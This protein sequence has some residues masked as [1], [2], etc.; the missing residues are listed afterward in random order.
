MENN[1]PSMLDLPLSQAQTSGPRPKSKRLFGTSRLFSQSQPQFCAPSYKQVTRKPLQKQT[2]SML[3]KL[4]HGLGQ[5]RII[6]LKC[7]FDEESSSEFFSIW[8]PVLEKRLNC[9]INLLST[10]FSFS[11]KCEVIEGGTSAVRDLCEDFVDSLVSPMEKA[12]KTFKNSRNPVDGYFISRGRYEI[13]LLLF[14]GYEN[15]NEYLFEI[16]TN[17]C[18]HLIEEASLSIDIEDLEFF[19]DVKFLS[20]NFYQTYFEAGYTSKCVKSYFRRK[21]KTIER[22]IEKVYRGSEHYKSQLLKENRDKE[23]VQ[24]GES[25]LRK[26]DASQVQNVLT[27]QDSAKRRSKLLY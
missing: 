19:F 10:R 2:T 13:S 9:E 12:M 17:F 4:Q 1:K 7:S 25:S 18:R 21:Y 16:Q 11:E 5:K 3:E 26:R 14:L 20:A 24:N 23:S 8:K 15:P 27:Q 22:Y 6:G